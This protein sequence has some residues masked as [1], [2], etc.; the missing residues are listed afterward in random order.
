MINHTKWSIF[1]LRYAQAIMGFTPTNLYLCEM[2]KKPKLM[3]RN[4]KRMRWYLI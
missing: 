3:I 4:Y 1:L 2:R